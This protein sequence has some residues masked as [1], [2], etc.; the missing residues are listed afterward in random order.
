[1]SQGWQ[2]KLSA[3]WVRWRR[4]AAREKLRVS[5]T[6]IK[7]LRLARSMEDFRMVVNS[8]QECIG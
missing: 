1:M 4:S 7:A 6:A 2:E 3:G 8:S 5:A